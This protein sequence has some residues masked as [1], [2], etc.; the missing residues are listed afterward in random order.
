MCDHWCDVL[1]CHEDGCE[2]EH[3]PQGYGEGQGRQ[4]TAIDG[5]TQERDPQAS[6]DPDEGREHLWV[7][8]I[9][10]RGQGGT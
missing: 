10:E 8:G 1:F 7:E 9:K 6:D 2:E 3:D 5:Q 4:C